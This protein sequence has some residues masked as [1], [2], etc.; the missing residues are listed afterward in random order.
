MA[1]RRRIQKSP[2]KKTGK[3]YRAA[4]RAPRRFWLDAPLLR[5]IRAVLMQDMAP[6]WVRVEARLLD[7]LSRA[8]LA[9]ARENKLILNDRDA[10]A[11]ARDLSL[12]LTREIHA[13]EQRIKQANQRFQVFTNRHARAATVRE[14]RDF[15]LNF[16]AELGASGLALQ[17][18][19]RAVKRYLDHDAM[20][21]RHRILRREQER[22]IC[23]CLKR[24]GVLSAA[25]LNASPDKALKLWTQME[26]ERTCRE[27][28]DYRGNPMIRKEAFTALARALRALPPEVIDR[29]VSDQTIHAVYRA[30]MEKHEQVWY[31]LEAIALLAELAPESFEKVLLRWF[32]ESEAGDAIFFRARTVRIWGDLLRRLP[33]LAERAEL[34]W[35]DPSPYVRQAFAAAVTGGDPDFVDLW[36]GRA[37]SL[38]P[39]KEVRAAAL[40]QLPGAAPSLGYDR[41]VA[42][43]SSAL[44]PEAPD[45]V[46]RVAL[47]VAVDLMSGM[48]S[49]GRTSF[50]QTVLA[51]LEELHGSEVAD[52]IKREVSRTL[53][54]LWSMHDERARLAVA[55]LRRRLAQTKPGRTIRVPR[56]VATLE[57]DRLGRVLAVLAAEDFGLDLET[58]IRGMRLRRG[59]VFGFRWWRLLHELR[60]PDPAKRQGISH[61]IGRLSRSRF[62]APSAL[63]AELAPAKVPGEPLVIGAEAGWRPFLPLV[64]DG[65]SLLDFHLGNKPV[66]FYTSE[67]VTVMYPPRSPLRRIAAYWT[68]T[69]RFREYAALRNWSAESGNDENAYI[70]A[71]RRLGFDVRLEP[72]AP[73]RRLDPG[74]AKF[75]AGPLPFL[76]PG[77]VQRIQ[78]YLATV[79]GNTLSELTFFLTAATGLFFGRHAYGNGR[80]RLARAKLPLVIGG[81]GT[82]GKSGTERLKAALF[83]SLGYSVFAKT[84]GCEAMFVFC[85]P[86]E[87]L[88]EMPIFRP[89]DKATIWEQG[90]VVRL[91]AGFGTDVFLWECMGLRA[92]Y[93]SI[94]Q[95]QWMRDDFST[96]TNT[97]PDHEDIQGPAGYDIP[98]VMTEFIP[99]RATLLTTEE[100]M[101]PILRH[102]ARRLG[103]E[104]HDM[105]WLEAGLLTSDVL[106]RFPYEAHP[107]NIALVLGLAER[108]GIPRDYALREMA[109]RVVPD[110]GVL[111]SYPPAPIQGRTLVFSNGMSANERHGC[112]GNWTRLGFDKVDP[113]EEPAVFLTGV[114]N[115]RADRVSRSQIFADIMV[116]DLSVDC[117]VLIGSNLRGMM[118]YLETSWEAFAGGYAIFGTGD[119]PGG[120]LQTLARKLRI[121]YEPDMVRNRLEIMLGAMNEGPEAGDSEAWRPLLALWDRPDALAESLKAWPA[122]GIDGEEVLRFHRTY[123][124]WYLDY[125]ACSDLLA[126]DVDGEEARTRKIFETAHRWFFDRLVVVEDVYASGDH[127]I[128]TIV[129]HTPPGMTNRAMGLQNIKGTG[130]DFIYRFQA[131]LHCHQAL[132]KLVGEDEERFAEGLSDLMTLRDYGLLGAELAGRIIER[133]KHAPISQTERYQ[134]QLA[135]IETRYRADLERLEAR[136]HAPS[137]KRSPLAR[138]VDAVERFFDLGDA[139]R[140]RKKAMAIYRDL[141][142]GR[143]SRVRAVSELAALNQRQKGGWLWKRVSSSA[144]PAKR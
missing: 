109:D 57:P 115:N 26:V 64:E 136:L 63:L 141:V 14:K 29:A 2:A 1:R 105:G 84:T 42:L 33:R 45:F 130:L 102:A 3:R 5:R 97:Y 60:H 125:V 41:T 87:K 30:S 56:E 96:I 70:A 6:H 79:Y 58:G 110:L 44:N 93:V 19:R 133:A 22:I 31:H 68:L 127:I 24:F 40:L 78:E 103:T 32:D 27:I 67:G 111:Q 25:V 16:A 135:V 61:V 120:R 117:M 142:K 28:W 132:Q 89:F 48:D 108:L 66:R 144:K 119:T 90:D 20:A 69:L 13:R 43:W 107:Y 50:Y 46:L 134:A 86:Y 121:P 112:L 114:I 11:T 140:R 53:E 123:L 51:L 138:A 128:Q 139:V 143:I 81:W 9:W 36:L 106:A 59:P 35:A 85:T 52:S 72:L 17:A 71:L 124:E 80:I 88:L 55:A 21:D 18:D 62:R 65:L 137:E 12:F 37:I 126:K 39:A 10:W 113:R 75:F 118:G 34:I 8:F 54:I 38:D 91:A 82:R 76:Q 104:L 100:S 47:E 77:F 101:L 99:K 23:F 116:R 122:G 95:R 83:A 4:R 49:A 129:S 131:W 94:L 15:I 92:S 73:E 98:L 74:V 7:K